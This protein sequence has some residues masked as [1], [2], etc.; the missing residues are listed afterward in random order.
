MRLKFVRKFPCQRFHR[1]NNKMNRPKPLFGKVIKTSSFRDLILSETEYAPF[2]ELPAHSHTFAYFC[3]VLNGNYNERRVGKNYFCKPS[4]LVFHSQN[5]VHSNS[6]SSDGGRCLNIRLKDSLL[7]RVNEYAKLPE[8]SIA[9][10][11]I[12]LSNS[13]GKLYR[14]FYE[15]DDFSNLTIE[16]IVLETLAEIARSAKTDENTRPKWLEVTKEIL[17]E[18]FSE[19]LSLNY[20]AESVGRHPVHLAREFRKHFRCTIGEYIRRLRVDF[21]AR[22]LSKSNVSLSEIALNAGFSQQSHFTKTF[23]LITGKTPTEFRQ[24]SRPR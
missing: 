12:L 24:S 21:T 9:V 5:D 10:N 3:F 13:I 4:T 6:F 1:Y 2:T 16:G 15:P 14:E 19:S 23:K 20:I 8:N 11:E 18:K 17:H 7:N 22:E